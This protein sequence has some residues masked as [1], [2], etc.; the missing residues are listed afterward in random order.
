MNHLTELDLVMYADGALQDTEAAT[1]ADHLAGCG[2]CKTRLAGLAAETRTLKSALLADE[3]R[4]SPPAATPGFTRT[5]SLGQF[6]MANVTTGLLIYLGQFL[7]KTL[8]GDLVINAISWF[9]LVP[10]PDAFELTVRAVTYFSGEGST[11]IDTYISIIGFIV[12]VAGLTG[13]LLSLRRKFGGLQ[14]CLPLLLCLFVLS[15]T[16]AAALEVR[17]DDKLLAVSADQTID[18]SLVAFG[19]T[20]T[21]DGK[22]TGNVIAVGERV[23]VTGEIGG[24]LMTAAESVTVTGSIGGSAVAAG[25][26]IN[27]TGARITGDLLGAAGDITLDDKTLIGS[28]AGLAAERIAIGGRINRDLWALGESVELSGAVGEDLEI[29]T[30]RLNLLGKA[31]IGGDLRLHT[32]TNENLQ[33]ASS[34]S[35]G[36]EVLFLAAE[37]PKSTNRYATGRFYLGQVLY[38]GGQFVV[39]IIMFWL[40]PGLGSLSLA[41]GAMGLKTAG[42]GLVALV[43]VPVIALIA[44]VTLIGL[45]IGIISFLAWGLTLYLS[46][47]LVASVIGRTL[48]GNTSRH[49]SLPLTLLVGLGVVL[50][51]VNLPAIG[52]VISF[53]LTI[54]GFGLLVQALLAYLA[55][56]ERYDAS[57]SAG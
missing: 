43:S 23:I 40:I 53:L 37:K 25:S 45:P 21:I 57:T 7:W 41:P 30:E 1:V 46:K 26:S 8:L 48:L 18:D 38:L 6:A 4:V 56:I 55:D 44:A 39:G 34:A 2:D 13:L 29:Y 32:Q 17:H 52:G 35:I 19:N 42:I 51:A 11:M 10:V 54:V 9:T 14:L 16:P 24:T 3:V 15:P 31:R 28:N 36:G 5:M 47:I 33:V 20:I 22:V 27:L 50:I 49:G 12:L